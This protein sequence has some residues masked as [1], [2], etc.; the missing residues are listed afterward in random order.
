MMRLLDSG[1]DVMGSGGKNPLIL[2]AAEGHG[3]VAEML[4]ANGKE[5]D[6]RIFF[7]LLRKYNW[8]S[9]EIYGED[10]HRNRCEE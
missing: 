6:W 3:D 5:E 4:L 7:N 10:R 2:A 8:E 1:A 9:R